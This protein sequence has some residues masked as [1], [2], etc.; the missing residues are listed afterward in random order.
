MRSI[1][2]PEEAMAVIDIAGHGYGEFEGVIADPN[3]VEI[4]AHNYQVFKPLYTC[5]TN[6]RN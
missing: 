1:F 3:G 4:D 5:R 6:Y 2:G